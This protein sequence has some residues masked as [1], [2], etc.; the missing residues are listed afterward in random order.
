MKQAKDWFENDRVNGKMHLCFSY[1]PKQP[2]EYAHFL[3]SFS[4][5]LSVEHIAYN[6]LKFCCFV[7]LNLTVITVLLNSKLRYIAFFSSIAY[8]VRV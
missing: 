1:K 8:P 4:Y 7:K 5:L 3:Q 6:H 2:S